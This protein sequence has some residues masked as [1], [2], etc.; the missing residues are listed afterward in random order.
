MFKITGRIKGYIVLAAWIIAHLYRIT[1]ALVLV[2]DDNEI[3]LEEILKFTR[4]EGPIWVGEW[5]KGAKPSSP[6][7]YDEEAYKAAVAAAEEAESKAEKSA[8]FAQS[9][10]SEARRE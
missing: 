10:R 3:T 7:A 6:P 9:L 1:Q 2:V 5:R 8:R 4:D